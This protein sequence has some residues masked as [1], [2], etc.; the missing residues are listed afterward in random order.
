VYG[1]LTRKY[2]YDVNFTA[3]FSNGLNVSSFGIGDGIHE[4]RDITLGMFDSEN[5]VI[6]TYEQEEK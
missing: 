4:T 3:R 6:V 5:S 1:A 2:V